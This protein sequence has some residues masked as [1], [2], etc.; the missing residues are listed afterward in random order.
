[1]GNIQ[2]ANYKLIS[3]DKI[4]STQTYAHEMV[5]N[6][7][8]TDK[9]VI[10]A[11][12]QSA[13]RGRYRRTWVSHHGNLYVSFIFKISDR[14]PRL[15]YAVA[16]AIAETM[17]QFGIKPNIKW[18]NDILIDGKKVSGVLIEYSKDFV[19]IGIG[20]NIKSNPTVQKYETTKLENYVKITRDELLSAL[21]KSLDLWMDRDFAIV[22]T[23]WTE[24]AAGINTVVTHRGRSAE[25]IGL[26]EDGALVLRRGSEY[27]LTYGDEISI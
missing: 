17:I 5:A 16:V 20:V 21:M 8:A 15:S 26:N 7:R 27:L 10:L 2:L 18:P 13:G 14:D 6:D 11:E 25:L 9:M 22:R 3:F 23:R 12:A 24:L 1:M 4:P 19:I